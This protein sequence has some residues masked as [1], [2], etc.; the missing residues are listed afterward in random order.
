MQY[1][2]DFFYSLLHNLKL[3]NCDF[4]RWSAKSEMR[5]HSTEHWGMQVIL[6]F[7]AIFSSITWSILFYSVEFSSEF[8]MILECLSISACIGYSPHDLMQNKDVCSNIAVCRNGSIA[9]GLSMPD[10]WRI[11]ERR[12]Q[13]IYM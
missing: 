9:Q 8:A 1:I 6:N 2:A 7:L 13:D 10:G 4:K 12:T 5:V 11:V 3:D